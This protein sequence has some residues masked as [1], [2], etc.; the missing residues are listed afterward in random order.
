MPLYQ[1]INSLKANLPSSRG[2]AQTFLNTLSP[3]VQQQLIAAIYLGREHIHSSKLREDEDIEMS[4]LY[5]DHIGQDEYADILWEKGDNVIT[6][7]NKLEECAN[8]SGF[9][10]NTL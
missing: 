1:A 8:A 10:L 9:D 5:T 7:L 3:S 4:R 6:Y 2:A